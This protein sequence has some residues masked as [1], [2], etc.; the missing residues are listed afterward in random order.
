MVDERLYEELVA[1]K[2]EDALMILVFNG[3]PKSEEAGYE[4]THGPSAGQSDHLER[5]GSPVGLLRREIR[6]SC[7]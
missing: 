6:V 1:S 7:M 4:I 2:G 5:I 3:W